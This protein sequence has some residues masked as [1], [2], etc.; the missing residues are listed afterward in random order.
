MACQT[1][2]ALTS[3]LVFELKAERHDEGEDTFEVCV[4]G[5]SSC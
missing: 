2:A 5:G 3:R 4:Q 1:P